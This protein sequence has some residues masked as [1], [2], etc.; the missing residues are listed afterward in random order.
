LERFLQFFALGGTRIELPVE[1]FHRY[2]FTCLRISRFK[3]AA[4]AARLSFV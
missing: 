2:E 1:D 3:K 4:A